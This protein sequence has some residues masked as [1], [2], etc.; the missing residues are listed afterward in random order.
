MIALQNA[1]AGRKPTFLR[2]SSA[3]AMMTPILGD[4]G[5]GEV[6]GRRGGRPTFEHGGGNRGFQRNSFAFLDGTRQGVVVM[7][8]SDTGGVLVAEIM[9]TLGEAYGWGEAA[10]PSGPFRRAPYVAPLPK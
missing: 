3:K 7:T 4:Y 10:P 2:Q 6:L 5:L 9:R 1:Y 8:N